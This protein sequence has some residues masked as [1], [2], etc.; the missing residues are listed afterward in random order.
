MRLT[1]SIPE[2]TVQKLESL[3]K[4]EGRSVSNF[5]TRL[6]EAH[7]ADKGVVVNPSELI[8][9]GAELGMPTAVKVLSR[10][11][12]RRTRKGARRAA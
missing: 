12:V 4:A 9:L 8:D 11:L 6:I 7:L 5:T 1:L 3:A 10:E 2:P